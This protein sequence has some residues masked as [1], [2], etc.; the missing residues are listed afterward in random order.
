MLLIWLVSLGFKLS[1]WPAYRSTDFAVHAYWLRLTQTESPFRWY[2]DAQSRWTLDYPPLFAWF[3]YLLGALLLPPQELL[4]HLK[5][6]HGQCWRN[7]SLSIEDSCF[8]DKAVFWHR[9]TVAFSEL[10][11]LYVGVLCFCNTWPA[12][13]TSESALTKE[14]MALTMLLASFDPNLIVLDHIHFQYNGY[15]MGLLILSLAALRA[16]RPVLGAFLFAVLLASKHIFLYAAPLFFVYLLG[17]YCVSYNPVRFIT[18][19]A[20]LGVVVV[21]VF[22]SSIFSVCSPVEMVQNR[23]LSSVQNFA[24]CLGQVGRRLFPVQERGLVHAYWAPNFWA[25]YAGTDK[26]LKVVLSKLWGVQFAASAGDG[27][28]GSTQGLVQGE[29]RFDVLPQVP[30]FVTA[31]LSLLGM[32]PALLRVWRCRQ[33]QLLL[34]AYC[35]CVMSSIF[36]GYHVHEKALLMVSLPM[37]LAALDSAFDA[38]LYLKLTWT[39]Q[40]ALAPLLFPRELSSFKVILLVTHAWFAFAALDTFHTKRKQEAR[41][42]NSGLMALCSARLADGVYLMGLCLVFAVYEYGAIV[43]SMIRFRIASHPQALLHRYPFLPLM[44]VSVYCALGVAKCWSDMYVLLARKQQAIESYGN[45]PLVR[46]LKKK[47]T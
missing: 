25:L 30:T 1:L 8:S 12:S 36:F 13:A 32:V 9:A 27:G 34:H 43:E 20:T 42:R 21:F 46:P 7:G 16:N 31:M 39:T 40:V 37:A 11:V 5:E 35:C 38:Q 29:I 26:V 22:A 10:A 15:L 4:S 44:L 2:Y 45:S 47:V 6:E 3:E 18:R 23:D 19:V 17:S 28:V 33:P 41:M 14:K 24:G